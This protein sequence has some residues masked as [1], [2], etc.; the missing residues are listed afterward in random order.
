MPLE[1]AANYKQYIEMIDKRYNYR[2]KTEDKYPIGFEA[3]KL[4]E[5]ADE[6]IPKANTEIPF[7]PKIRK[8]LVGLM[9]VVREKMDVKNCPTCFY[10]NSKFNDNDGL[11][12]KCADAPT[13]IYWKKK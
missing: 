6:S 12:T 10:E 8:R 11:C 3:L 9:N 5:T 7:S 13:N 2:V 4:I 1:K